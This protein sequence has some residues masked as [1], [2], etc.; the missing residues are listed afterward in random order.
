MSKS[1]IKALKE[2]AL[3]TQE[4][5]AYE[6]TTEVHVTGEPLAEPVHWR[7][8][9]W[10]VTSHGIEARDGK[11]AIAG[12]RVWEETLGHGWID[13]MSEKDWVDIHDFAEALRIARARWP[14]PVV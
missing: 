14:K 11:Y 1:V 8:K 5:P 10:A 7:G 12:N 3:Q 2:R 13:H 6:S 4:P 9:Q